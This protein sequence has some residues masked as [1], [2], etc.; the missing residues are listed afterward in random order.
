MVRKDGVVFFQS[1][2]KRM[3]VSSG[4]NVYPSQIENVIESHEAVLKCT[5]IG[6]PHKY[7]QEVAKAIIVLKNGLFTQWNHIYILLSIK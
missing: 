4:Y 5:V 3:I 7:K 6:I 2:L 1:R